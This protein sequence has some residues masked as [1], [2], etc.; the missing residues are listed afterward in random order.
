MLQD[1]PNGTW[2]I[3][4]IPYQ[5][6]VA[7]RSVTRRRSAPDILVSW[8]GPRCSCRRTRSRSDCPRSEGRSMP[9]LS[10]R[11]GVTNAPPC[12]ARTAE[13]RRH[14]GRVRP[15]HVDSKGARSPWNDSGK[16]KRDPPQGD[17]P[18]ELADIVAEPRPDGPEGTPEARHQAR[19][20]A[21]RRETVTAAPRPRSR[22]ARGP[23]CSLP[24][25][26]G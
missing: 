11:G 2:L 15:A 9:G 20:V 5:R 4:L 10:P 14:F 23:S 22:S 8:P 3:A 26:A 16:G 13:D 12:H 21:A 25:R 24:D 1:W 18:G 17:H 6:R 19:R 7:R